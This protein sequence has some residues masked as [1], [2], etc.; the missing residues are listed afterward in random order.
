M[1]V[2]KSENNERG[3]K[4]TE[5]YEDGVQHK[6]LPVCLKTKKYCKHVF[7]KPGPHFPWNKQFLVHPCHIVPRKGLQISSS[8]HKEM[9]SLPGVPICQVLPGSVAQASKGYF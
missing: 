2:L 9:Q 7:S 3:M 4:K 5:K 8:R 1:L 6:S